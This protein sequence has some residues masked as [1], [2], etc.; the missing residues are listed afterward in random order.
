MTLARVEVVWGDAHTHAGWHTAGEVVADGPLLQHSV[1]YV[2]PGAQ[3]G[4]LVIAQTDDG[5]GSVGDLLAIPLGMVR[6]VVVLV[7]G[8]RLPLDLD[9]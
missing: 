1:G 9:I 8:A 7:D 2:V 4:H 3:H 6:S 5:R